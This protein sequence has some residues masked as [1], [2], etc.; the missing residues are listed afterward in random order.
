M[1][2]N[3]LSKTNI[4]MVKTLINPLVEWKFIVNWVL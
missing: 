1:Y 2:G 3:E 4:D